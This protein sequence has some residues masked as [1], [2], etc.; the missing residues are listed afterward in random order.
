MYDQ[1]WDSNKEIANNMTI[2]NMLKILENDNLRKMFTDEEL[3]VIIKAVK[4]DLLNNAYFTINEQS[5]V[6]KEKQN[7]FNRI[8]KSM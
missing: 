1:S 7:D 2:S 4:L 6:I 8:K 3:A 5:R